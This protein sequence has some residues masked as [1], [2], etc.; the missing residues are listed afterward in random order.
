MLPLWLKNEA[1]IS[2]A[3]L[4]CNFFRAAMDISAPVPL[5]GLLDNYR[6][7]IIRGVSPVIVIIVTDKYRT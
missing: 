6:V 2:L 3:L 4:A 7:R 1:L 5:T